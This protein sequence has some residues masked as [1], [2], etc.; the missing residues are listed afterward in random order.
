MIP[1]VAKIASRDASIPL[2]NGN[3]LSTPKNGSKAREP[4]ADTPSEAA[5]ERSTTSSFSKPRTIGGAM[6]QKQKERLAGG[7]AAA[8]G[9]ASAP[10]PPPAPQPTDG[11]KKATEQMVPMVSNLYSRATSVQNTHGNGP[12]TIGE[13]MRNKSKKDSKASDQ[14]GDTPSEAASER[15]TTSNINRARTAG[16]AMRQRQKEML[17]GADASVPDPTP[18]VRP[19]T[20]GLKKK[21][22]EQI[23]NMVYCAASMTASNGNGPRTVGDA[24][25]AP[26]KSP[27][28]SVIELP[29]HASRQEIRPSTTVS[30]D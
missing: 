1:T 12:R 21:A 19:T 10:S 6:R 23:T 15:S 20:D 17:A 3:G 27:K 2:S 24:M 11:F 26:R 18:V 7:D 30:I 16:G 8:N 13:A 25:R 4:D 22:T 14:T 5:S 9:D 29:Q 28:A